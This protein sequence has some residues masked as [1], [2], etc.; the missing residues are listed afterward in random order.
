[1]TIRGKGVDLMSGEEAGVE[2][3]DSIV[4]MRLA[5]LV[6][7]V[8]GTVERACGLCDA[9]VAISPSTLEAFAG[10]ELPPIWCFP[11]AN[12]VVRRGGRA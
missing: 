2:A 9:P 7:R 3:V 6:F 8:P 10:C 1:M 4:T 11:C 5:D 12:D